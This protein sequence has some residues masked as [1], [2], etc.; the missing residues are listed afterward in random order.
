MCGI[1]GYV[2]PPGRVAE[3]AEIVTRM[4]VTLA[5]RG[6]DD[7]GCWVDPAVG[8]A[9]GHRR[10]SIVDLSPEGHQ[11]MH[12]ASGRYVI[13]FNGEIYNFLE[14]RAELE[15]R[16]HRFR[17][18]SDT[19]VMLAAFEEWGLEASVAKFNGMFAFAI[20][21]RELRRLQLAR[22]RLG[23]KPL[24]YGWMG[25][26]F[27]FG[28][29][30]KALQAHPSF[31]F[32]VDRDVLALFLR[33]ACIPAPYCICPGIR[34][35]MPATT[36]T[37]DPSRPGYLASPQPY[38]SALDVLVH[39][40]A[41]P[42]TGSE[43]E[44]L[45]ELDRIGRKA[46][47]LRM[48][49]DVPL[50]AFLSGG[51]DSATVVALMQVQ[52][53]RP[54]RTF[55][56][57]FKESDFNEAEFAAAVAR[58]LGTDHTELYLTPDDM[59]NLVPRLA[60]MYDEPFADSSQLPTHMVSVMAR[61]YV[62]VALSGD[63][64]DEL[65]GGY[66]THFF[67]SSA[68]RSTQCVPYPVRRA[69]AGALSLV[70]VAYWDRMMRLV[71]PALPLRYRQVRRTGDKL[72]LL[73]EMLGCRSS[74]QWHMRKIS[75]WKSPSHVVIGAHE[76][77]R[78]LDEVVP[79]SLVPDFTRRMMLSDLLTYLPDDL[80]V[81]IDRASMAVS[82]ETR[83]PF[84]DP[85]LIGFA[86]SLPISLLVN[87]WQGKLLQRK[88]LYRYVPQQLVDRPKRGFSVALGEWLRGALRD[89]TEDLISK[90]RLEEQGFFHPAPIRQMWTA[91]LLGQSDYS[92]ELWAVLMFQ[93]W[94]QQ[95]SGAQIRLKTDQAFSASQSVQF[96]R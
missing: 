36:V 2:G 90:T 49:A 63:G 43:E 26:T 40:Q 55:T 42:F 35:L 6:P 39:G 72:H 76:L 50:G 92:N 32:S 18:H 68:W 89:W 46:V 21:D 11:P 61:D 47:S 13:V 45:R 58:H 87:Q 79:E 82:L 78:G 70:P 71:R 10:L 20:W 53:D 25:E 19:E 16:G 41:D 62:K 73:S 64:G 84:L 96:R 52:S 57:G 67:W 60:T 56:I 75:L 88:L 12:S 1:T 8:V 5:H 48:I 74:S 22:D 54:V 83:V 91:H 69:A 24:Y 9:L 28:S 38:W 29:E 17:G 80:L 59:L 86:A 77:S 33:H 15:S 3:M 51:V 85:E 66:V 30:L 81:K 93:A 95:V 65:F 37:I 31:R 7:S 44:A 34:Q 94:L 23:E 14:L 4:A 27:I